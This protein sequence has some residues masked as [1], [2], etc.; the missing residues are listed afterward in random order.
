MSNLDL[1]STSDL[2]DELA[3]RHREIIVIRENKKR[4]NEDDVYVK[5]GFGSKGRKDIGFDLV[6]A[7]SMLQSAHWQ[8]VHDYLED[9][10]E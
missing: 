5:T 4:A 10:R 1:I 9:V 3:C 2:I 8:L 7:T 6:V